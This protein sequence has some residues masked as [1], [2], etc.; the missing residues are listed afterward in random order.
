MSA[1]FDGNSHPDEIEAAIGAAIASVDEKAA[2]IRLRN[3]FRNGVG[4]WIVS[5]AVPEG[6]VCDVETLASAA[7][8]LGMRIEGFFEYSGDLGAALRNDLGEPPVED[9]LPLTNEDQSCAFCAGDAPVWVHP[10]KDVKGSGLPT[11]WTVCERCERLVDS[12]RDTELARLFHAHE[13][14]SYRAA[15][16][17]LRNFR[18]ADLGAKP[19]R[20]VPPAAI[21]V[22][23]TRQTS[24][25]ELRRVGRVGTLK[26]WSIDTSETVA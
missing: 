8:G 20:H 14:T 4:T 9:G 5:L 16:R 1:T 11:F 2:P 12:G 15:K 10:F 26:A 25:A 22:S 23:R 21:V 17:V 18:V 13:T 24:A 7:D 6:H 19:I 3:R